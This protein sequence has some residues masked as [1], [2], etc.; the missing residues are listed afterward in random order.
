MFVLAGGVHGFDEER[1]GE[2][3]SANFLNLVWRGLRVATAD[4]RTECAGD[5]GIQHGLVSG[6]NVAISEP[7]GAKADLSN[8]VR[9]T[10]P[11][12][13][14]GAKLSVLGFTATAAYQVTCWLVLLGSNLV[15]VWTACI[16][17]DLE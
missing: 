5:N 10:P 16:A 11:T 7:V 6:S 12:G 17:A 4:F 8:L 9:I 15:W 1:D 13:I 14:R 2:L 3:P